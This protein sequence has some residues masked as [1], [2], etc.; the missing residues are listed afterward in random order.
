MTWLVA[1]AMSSLLASRALIADSLATISGMPAPS[2]ASR[3][4]STEP[5]LSWISATPVR[6]VKDS[7]ASVSV[8]IGTSLPIRTRASTR[9]GSLGSSDSRRTSPTWMPLYCTAPPTVS[10]VTDS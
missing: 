1:L 6:P 4:A 3:G 7:L 9:L 2:D 10:P 5:P 8:L